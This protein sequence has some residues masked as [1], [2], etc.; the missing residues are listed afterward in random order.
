M[1]TVEFFEDAA[2]AEGS[3]IFPQAYSPL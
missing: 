1:N 2:Q 3:Q